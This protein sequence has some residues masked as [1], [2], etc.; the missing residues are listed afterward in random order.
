MDAGTAADGAT[1]DTSACENPSAVES[2]PALRALLPTLGVD[3]TPLQVQQLAD[4]LNQLLTMNERMNLTAI[5]DREVAEVR[6]LADS[7]TLV[8]HVPATARTLIDVGSGGGVPGLPL[9]IALP[10]VAVTLLDATGKKVRFLQETADALGLTQV[11]AVQGRA[12]EAGHDPQL[13][14]QFDVVTARAVARLATLM[15]YALPLLKP[16]GVG[17]F[18][19]GGLAQEEVDEATAAL[20]ILGRAQ[21]ALHQSPLDGTTLVV[22]TKTARTP[23]QYPRR[24]GVPTQTPLVR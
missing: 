2:V 20:R 21:V 11:R 1:T 8:P 19:K 5:R 14:E 3:L 16:G 7:L 22:V 9:A 10:H 6:L 17:I 23:K 12:E 18:P 24:V 15:E 4:Y 13:R